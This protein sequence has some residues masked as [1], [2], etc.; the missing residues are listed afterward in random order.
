MYSVNSFKILLT[1]SDTFTQ[2]K[3]QELKLRIEDSNPSI[4]AISEVK[5]K[6]YK[7]DIQISE[8]NIDGYEILSA[9]LSKSSPGRGMLMY[10]KDSLK[11][12]PYNISNSTFEENLLCEIQVGNNEKILVGSLYRS[13]NGSEENLLNFANYSQNL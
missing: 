11:Y 5:P 8:F 3:L 2:Y 10:I 6:N 1:N 12:S 4:I 9:N 7:R 13:P